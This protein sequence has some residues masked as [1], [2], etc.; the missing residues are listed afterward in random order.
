VF[1]ELNYD[2]L[3]ED[4]YP[5]GDLKIETILKLMENAGSRHSDKAG[6]NILKGA[7]KGCTWVLTD[8]Y[9]L[10]DKTPKYGKKL[11]VITW[12]MGA[13]SLFSTSRNFELYC[14]GEKVGVGTTKWVRFDLAENKPA[15]VTD[16]IMAGYEPESKMVFEDTKLPKIETP[17][18]WSRICKINLRRGD[19]DFNHHVHNLTYLDYVMEVLPE[20]VYD[21]HHFNRI[22]LNYHAPVKAGEEVTAKY[23][24]LNNR[25]VVFIYGSDDSLRTMVELS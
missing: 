11:K 23:S 24:F 6:D 9:V 17:A 13:T 21:L 2:P 14:D 4:F 16:E 7:A 10:I 15:K 3:L 25:H 1:V 5:N 22:R 12:T 8:W 20:D 18:E 19:I